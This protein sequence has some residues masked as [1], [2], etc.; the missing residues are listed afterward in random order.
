MTNNA[1]HHMNTPWLSKERRRIRHI[2]TSPRQDCAIYTPT[3]TI[4]SA[5][6]AYKKTHSWI[7]CWHAIAGHDWVVYTSANA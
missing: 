2:T 3:T 4:A 6:S 5:A 7:S 1:L